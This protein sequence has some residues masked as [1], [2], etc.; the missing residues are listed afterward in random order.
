MNRCLHQYSSYRWN[1]ILGAFVFCL[2]IAV[3]GGMV[4]AKEPGPIISVVVDGMGVQSDVSPIHR[5]GRML[6]PIRVVAEATGSE[7][8]YDSDTQKVLLNKKGRHITLTIGSQTAN[9][10]G[11]RLKMDV[12]PIIVNKRTLVPIRFISEAFGYQVQWDETSAVAYIQSKTV[13]DKAAS[14]KYSFN[15]YVVQQGDTLSK[16]A[17]R[18]DTNMSAIQKNN[19]LSSDELLVGQ[20]L[21]LPEGAQRA[22]HPIATKVADDQLIGKQFRFPFH[23]NSRYEPYG[24]S[25]GSDREWTESNSGSVRNHEGIDIMAPKGTP[26]YSVSDGTINKVGWNTYGGWRV[27]ITDEN[28]QYRMYYAHLQAYA[29]GLHVGKT[30]KAGQLIGFVGDTGY[31]GTGTVGMFEPHLHFGLYRNSTGKAIDPYDYLRIWEQNKVESL[32]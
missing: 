31:G 15:P 4:S 18:H 1:R 7:V 9:V 6:V 24:D 23:D 30:I 11:K 26:I 8:S 20:I 25:F 10:D 5:N 32:L 13:E 3:S 2:M 16:I 21:F 19:P 27:N 29:P 14:V 22:E 12:S 28:G 17:A